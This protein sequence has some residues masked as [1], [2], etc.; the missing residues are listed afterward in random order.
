MRRAAAA[1][2]AAGLVAV[3]SGCN[4]VSSGIVRNHRIDTTRYE[5]H[6][7]LRVEHAVPHDTDAHFWVEVPRIHYVRCDPGE[8]WEEAK[9][10]GCPARHIPWPGEGADVVSEE[11]AT[12]T[13]EQQQQD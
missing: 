3:L 7:M 13:E 2:A 4:A 5:T 9:A 12:W 1:V 11:D 8:L 6:Y 10:G